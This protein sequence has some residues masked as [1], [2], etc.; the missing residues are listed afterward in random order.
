MVSF[1]GRIFAEIK[2]PTGARFVSRLK[3]LTQIK[4]VHKSRNPGIHIKRLETSSIFYDN[5]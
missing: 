4:D 5:A 3:I 1:A 2:M